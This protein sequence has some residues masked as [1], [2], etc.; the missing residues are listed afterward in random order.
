MISK[1]LPLDAVIHSCDS[2]C[3]VGEGEVESVVGGDKIFTPRIIRTLTKPWKMEEA[4]KI[5]LDMQS[6]QA[7]ADNKIVTSAI[8]AVF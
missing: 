4:V 8:H 5:S 2:V 3:L 1:N 6:H 7:I